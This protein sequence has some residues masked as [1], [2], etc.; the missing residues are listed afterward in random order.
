MHLL[1]ILESG[2]SDTAFNAQKSKIIDGVMAELQNVVANKGPTTVLD[3]I[4]D[5]QVDM[6]KVDRFFLET[7]STGLTLRKDG[8]RSMVDAL[9]PPPALDKKSK[10]YVATIFDRMI[11][12]KEIISNDGYWK[13]GTND[14]TDPRKP[15]RLKEWVSYEKTMYLAVLGNQSPITFD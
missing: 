4:I 12:N 3:E 1:Q 9:P 5:G 6:M 10:D 14:I 8:I 7:R 2:N 11:A 13:E 15:R